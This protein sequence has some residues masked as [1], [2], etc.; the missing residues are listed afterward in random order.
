MIMGVRVFKGLFFFFSR[1]RVFKAHNKPQFLNPICLKFSGKKIG[2]FF[3]YQNLFLK[4]D[5]KFS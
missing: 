3:G 1:K 5:F 2:G 4:E